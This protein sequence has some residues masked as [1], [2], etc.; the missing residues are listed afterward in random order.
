MSPGLLSIVLFSG[1]E[2]AFTS[3]LSIDS[4][5]FLE[6]FQNQEIVMNVNMKQ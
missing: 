4:A 5:A 6:Q 1:M 2:S 3:C